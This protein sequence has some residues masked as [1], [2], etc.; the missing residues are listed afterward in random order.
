MIETWKDVLGFEGRYK[1]S[2][3]GK[4][5]SIKGKNRIH[6]ILAPCI[7]KSTGY[8]YTTL[9]NKKLVRHV[10]IHVLVAEAF[11][12]KPNIMNVCVNHLDGNK[13]NNN[14]SN[15]EWTTLGDNI[16][17]ALNMGLSDTRGE[18]HVNSKLKSA[19]AYAIKYKMIGFSYKEL[20]AIFGVSHELINKIKSGRRWKHITKDYKPSSSISTAVGS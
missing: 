14:V 3:T 9:N 7:Q 20:G 15:L 8:F 2:N 5:I 18:K 12:N 1:I 6:K 4:L 19:E 13:L 11:L 17:H 10:R 16:R